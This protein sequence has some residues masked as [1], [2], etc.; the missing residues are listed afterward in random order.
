MKRDCWCVRRMLAKTRRRVR[1]DGLK[2]EDQFSPS[3]E[4]DGRFAVVHL[5]SIPMSVVTAGSP[6]SL[7][8][9]H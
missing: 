5:A 8:W 7:S 3:E 2:G 4:Q 1:Q 9:R 6:V